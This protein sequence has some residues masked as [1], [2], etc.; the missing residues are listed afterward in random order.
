M[1]W[2]GNFL[3]GCWGAALVYL[4]IAIILPATHKSLWFHTSASRRL[5]TPAALKA[6]IAWEGRQL[7]G[8]GSMDVFDI[9]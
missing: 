8:D 4:L 9:S 5:I 3:A 6:K 2:L 1:V 7:L